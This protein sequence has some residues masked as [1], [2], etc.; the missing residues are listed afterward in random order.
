MA[1]SLMSRPITSW[2]TTMSVMTCGY[3]SRWLPRTWIRYSSIGWRFFAA[4]DTTSIAVQ[5]PSALN[6][7]STGLPPRV[8]LA[9]VEG[10]LVPAARH[11]LEAHPAVVTE[12]DRLLGRHRSQTPASETGVGSSSTG[13]Q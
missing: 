4:I 13:A 8:R 2:V 3:S 12:L 5:A 9:V 7:V 1:T 11:R 10:E 6:R